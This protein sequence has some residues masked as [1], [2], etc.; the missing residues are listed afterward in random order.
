[1]SAI[2]LPGHD[3]TGIRAANPGPYTLSGTNSWI[4]GRNPGWLIDP[5]PA[6][7]EHVENL[8]AE[9]KGRGGLGGIALTHDHADH[10]EAVASVRALFPNAPLGAARGAVDVSLREGMEFGPL[11]VLQTPGHAP[12]HLA[13]FC[14][15]VGFSGDAVLGEGSVFIAPDPGALTAYLQGLGRLRRLGLEL[16]CPGHG[17]PV[18]EVDARLEQYLTHR[19]Q[20]ERR[21]LQA[22]AAGLRT[23]EEL[24]D[25]AWSDAP[26]ALR[27]AAAMTLAAHLDKLQQEGRLPPGVGC[28][29]GA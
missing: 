9:L 8:R 6:L 11:K 22:L 7:A 15:A 28:P 19:L 10:A 2:G 24:L 14:G 17:P 20:R 29:V 25:A 16:L 18:R 4:V 1:M 12:D 13:Y 21:L 3:I 23:E 26:P 5:G 27:P